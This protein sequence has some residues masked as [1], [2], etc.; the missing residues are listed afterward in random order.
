VVNSP[1]ERNRRISFTP[2]ATPITICAAEDE[3]MVDSLNVPGATHPSITQEFCNKENK[4][5][6]I[7]E[8]ITETNF[9]SALQTAINHF[10]DANTLDKKYKQSSSFSNSNIFINER[11][12]NTSNDS[13]RRQYNSLLIKYNELKEHNKKL[14]SDYASLRSDF[15]E[16]KAVL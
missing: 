16:T 11:R 14:M 6:S 12:E 15:E 13:I 2:E 1:E 4:L 8:E 9:M 5:N 3:F 7:A 10:E